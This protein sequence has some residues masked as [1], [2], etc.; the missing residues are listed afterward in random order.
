[1]SWLRL[2]QSIIITI[3]IVRNSFVISMENQNDRSVE[4]CEIVTLILKTKLFEVD[5]QKLIEK[6]RYFAA[7]LSA[8]YMDFHQSE[9]IIN[10]EIPFILFEVSLFCFFYS[11][12]NFY[13]EFVF[14]SCCT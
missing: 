6:S 1:M 4:R 5:K 13:V 12:I 8:N 14:Q 3:L 11:K 9:H 2:L 10:Y 7:L